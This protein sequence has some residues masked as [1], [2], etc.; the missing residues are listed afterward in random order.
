M[1]TTYEARVL[2]D[3]T[4]FS[5]VWP[6]SPPEKTKAEKTSLLDCFSVLLFAP[7]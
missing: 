2:N 4:E 6:Q 1:G 5:E 7:V 3:S